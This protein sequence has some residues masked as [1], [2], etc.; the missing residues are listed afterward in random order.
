MPR[1]SKSYTGTSTAA[2]E[3]ESVDTTLPNT[4]DSEDE[5]EF[6]AGS[7]IPLTGL[8]DAVATRRRR[9]VRNATQGISKASLR[10][11]ARRGG[12]SRISTLVYSE[13]RGV[14]RGFLES[15][16][17]DAICYTE[18]HS[19]Q[20]GTNTSLAHISCVFAARSQENSD[21]S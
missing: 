8:P 6:G 17:H 16:I 14:L 9:V 7:S 18:V 15:V 12:V 2:R 20:L 19:P 5:S 13:A 21:G 10:R 3:S 1:T 11:I 4:P